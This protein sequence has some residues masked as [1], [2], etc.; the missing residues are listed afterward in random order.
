[1]SHTQAEAPK[2]AAKGSLFSRHENLT[3]LS[4]FVG[5]ILVIVALQLGT[6]GI[7]KY[8]TF[9]SPVN[10]LN[11]MMQ[12]AVPGIVAVG[13]TLVMLSGGIDLSV[14]MLASLVSILVA[15]AISTWGLSVPVSIGLGILAAVVLETI[16]GFIISRTK[17]EPFIITLGGM[18]TFQGIALLVS[19][20]RE[21]TMN[22]ELDFLKTNL[23]AGA[24][25]PVTGLNLTIPPYVLFFFVIILLVGLILA[26]TKYGRRVYAVGTNPHAAFLAGINVKNMTLSVYAIMGLLVGIGSVLLLARINTGIITLG[27]NLE[28]DTIA[29]V[30]IGGTALRG[31][32][33]SM[34]GTLIGIFFLGSIGNAMNMLRLP[35][36]VQF[37]AKGLIVVIAV[38]AGDVSN[39]VSAY[40]TRR[41]EQAQARRNLAT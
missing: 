40:M 15:S 32:K 41:R 22:G 37:V 33:G 30:V 4:I 2:T 36:E 16:M 21:V 13:M 35:S 38:S 25:D 18:I 34:L 6:Q 7:G 1:M 28:I 10:L 29:M 11:I 27:Q 12:V 17:V 26:Y 19:H 23:I 14:G 20:S 8:P 39:Q 9:I 5:F 3:P 24:K 31:G